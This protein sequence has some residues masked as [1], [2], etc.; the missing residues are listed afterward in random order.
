LAPS[1][2]HAEHMQLGTNLEPF[3]TQFNQPSTVY[4][5]LLWTDCT[6]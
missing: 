2:I 3:L 1:D 4:C 6:A 5:V